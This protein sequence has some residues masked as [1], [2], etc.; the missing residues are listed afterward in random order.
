MRE[1]IK[2]YLVS[3]G[4]ENIKITESSSS[5]E[6]KRKKTFI[7]TVDRFKKVWRKSNKLAEE[8]GVNL[9]Q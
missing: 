8:H 5:K 2:K 6:R 1:K 4:G 7:T 3:I 9:V